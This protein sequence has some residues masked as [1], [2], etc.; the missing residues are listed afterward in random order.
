MNIQALSVYDVEE[1]RDL[2]S[3]NLGPRDRPK[4]VT[5]TFWGTF[6]RTQ[7]FATLESI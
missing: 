4:A 5:R 2:A 6:K 1:K 7:G 3:S